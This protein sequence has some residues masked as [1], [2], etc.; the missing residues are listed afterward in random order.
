M[1]SWNE[2]V[3]EMSRI[4]NPQ[5]GGA[6]LQTKQSEWLKKLSVKRGDRNVLFYGSAFLQKPQVASILLQISPEDINGYMSTMYG[7]DWTK[8]L[9]LILHTP[10]GVTNATETIVEYLHQKFTDI[11][12]IV[13][14][15]AMSA[16]T[17]ISLA[18]NRIVMGRQSQLGPI[19]PQMPGSGRMM[20]ARAIVDQFDR[21]REEIT[22]DR[23]QAAVWASVLQSLGPALLT[24]ARNALDYGEKMVERWLTRRR[25]VNDPDAVTKAQNTASYF[26]RSE[27]H[28]SHGRRI[29]RDEARSQNLD[30]EDLEVDQE[31][32]DIVLTNYHIGTLIFEKSPCVKFLASSHGQAW[33]KNI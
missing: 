24:E 14:T 7:M 27:K 26:N 21:A 10:G 33:I 30:V 17:M 5:Q 16:G 4:P 18:A 6:W 11:E 20:S 28:K 9:T 29:D 1:P 3:G 2:L 13:P 25:F 12:V 31:L 32:Q 19:D 22:A 15:Y 23:G 8:G